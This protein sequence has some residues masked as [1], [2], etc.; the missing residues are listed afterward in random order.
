MVNTNLGA[1]TLTSGAD[2][3]GPFVEIKSTTKRLE[4]SFLEDFIKQLRAAAKE[5]RNG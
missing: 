2:K 1:F 3:N 5:A 4:V